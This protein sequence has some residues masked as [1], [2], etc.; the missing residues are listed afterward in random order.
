MRLNEDRVNARI[1]QLTKIK[2]LLEEDIDSKHFI[3]SSIDLFD[4]NRPRIKSQA[5]KRSKN[6]GSFS[7][8]NMSALLLKTI[9]TPLVL[10]LVFGV[11]YGVTLMEL[12]DSFQ[13][14]K[15]INKQVSVLNEA[16]YQAN[17]L[18][19]AL[20][21]KTLFPPS[22]KMLIYN[23]PAEQQVQD[24]FEELKGINVR[25]HT[26]FLDD[27]SSDQFTQGILTK[28]LCQYLP[29][30]LAKTCGSM[31]KGGSNGIIFAN[32]DY[33]QMMI[34]LDNALSESMTQSKLA[35][36]SLFYLVKITSML[37][38][39]QLGYPILI[40]HIL[41]KFDVLV[42]EGA[43]AGVGILLGNVYI[44]GGLCSFY[45]SRIFQKAQAHRPIKEEDY[46]DYSLLYG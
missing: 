32:E 39:L 21:Y 25:L 5:D 43:S 40:N 18:I 19:C 3:D 30:P 35:E 16:S 37:S 13:S 11:L 44:C 12:I 22:M 29:G 15:T 14:F 4:N 38:M 6:Q 27:S 23:L 33:L 9:F 28:T 41:D 46:K 24:T 45:A 34:E 10:S 26:I 7:T 1:D 31:Y 20:N 36:I 8:K 42:G 17:M 2:T